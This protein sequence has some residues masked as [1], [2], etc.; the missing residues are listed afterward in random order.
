[1]LGHNYKIL[2]HIIN[3]NKKIIY[4]YRKN[5]VAQYLSETKAIASKQWATVKDDVARK[6]QLNQ[7]D[8]LPRSYLLRSSQLASLDMLFRD[9]VLNAIKTPVLQLEYTELFHENIS[10]TL[11]NFLDVPYRQM[12]S[13][14]KKQGNDIIAE[15][16]SNFDK[17][18]V[19]RFL[20]KVIDPEWLDSELMKGGD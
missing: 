1:M 8:F 12:I 2:Q 10:H 5:K 3:D 11:C 7:I 15:R 17:P 20:R 4:V 16:I 14:L 6:E 18:F 13:S 9:Y 19:N